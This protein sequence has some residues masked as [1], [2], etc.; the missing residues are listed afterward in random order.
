MAKILKQSA[1]VSAVTSGYWLKASC[2]V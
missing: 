1:K 2:T